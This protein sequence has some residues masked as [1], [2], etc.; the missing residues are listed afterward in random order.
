M[1]QIAPLHHRL[2][3]IKMAELHDPAID[4]ELH[5]FLQELRLKL[6]AEPIAM[7][8]RPQPAFAGADWRV[9]TKRVEEK[10]R[11]E[12]RRVGLA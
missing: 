4:A 12:E 11:L 5:F 2:E 7:Q 6:F 3:A 10:I 1:A 8:K 9:S